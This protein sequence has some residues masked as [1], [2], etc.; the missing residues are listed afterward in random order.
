MIHISKPVD[1]EPME[2]VNS[3]DALCLLVVL[4]GVCVIGIVVWRHP[5]P[6]RI[7]ALRWQVNGSM[8]K[9]KFPFVPRPFWVGGLE[10]SNKEPH[11][12]NYSLPPAPP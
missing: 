9:F 10:Q 6:T 1:K 8:V 7:F 4:I 2:V 12:F 3:V 11:G 5:P